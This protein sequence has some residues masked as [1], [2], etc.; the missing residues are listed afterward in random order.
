ML[1]PELKE[2]ILQ[3][4]KTS[5]EERRKE[6]ATTYYPT[7][8]EVL[9]CTGPSM[10][11]THKKYAHDF[12]NL[13][14]EN[15]WDLAF[16]LI[17][18][19]IFEAQQMAYMFIKHSSKAYKMLDREKLDRL[20]SVLE[21]W[22]SVDTYSVWFAGPAWRMGIL[23]NQDLLSWTESENRWIRRLA[24]VST[25][26]LNQKSHG[27]TGDVPRT[28]M[29]CERLVADRDDMVVKAMSWALREL[30]KV[31]QSVV[32]D[33]LD[34]HHGELASRVLREVTT[35]LITGRKNG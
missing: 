30:S 17:D 26:G 25:V 1:A 14:P 35:K 28:L 20:G 10:K 2:A 6:F 32:R 15:Q 31:D 3:D 22:V 7:R 4:L 9:G 18:T 8:M 5:G 11:A 12:K 23:S 21:N 27:G 16:D 19:D 13:T 34:K 24:L 33:F 29:I